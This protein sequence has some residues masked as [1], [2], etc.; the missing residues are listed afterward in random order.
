MK[1]FEIWTLLLG[2]AGAVGGLA[3]LFVWLEIRPIH[4]KGWFVRTEEVSEVRMSSSPVHNRARWLIGG[5]SLFALSLAL[6]GYGLYRAERPRIV[7]KIVE[8]PVD[9][10]V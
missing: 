3:T 9:R 7:E 4:I 8:K 1:P 6:S 10:I 5:I 2:A